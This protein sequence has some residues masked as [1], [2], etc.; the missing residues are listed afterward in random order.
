MG[1][2]TQLWGA[3]IASSADVDGRVCLLSETFLSSRLLRLCL[4]LGSLG[5]DWEAVTILT[6]PGGRAA[7]M[8]VV[9]ESNEG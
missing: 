1:A 4:V 5:K 9:G 2:S 6:G 7:T 3:T 8:G